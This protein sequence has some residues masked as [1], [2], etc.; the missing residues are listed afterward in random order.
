MAKLRQNK[1][2]KMDLF[3]DDNDVV[4]RVHKAATCEGSYCAIH[5]PSDHPMK[6]ARRVLRWPDPFSLKP[7]G[8]VERVCEHGVGHSDP[9]SVAFHDNNGLRGTGVHGCDGCCHPTEEKDMSTN[10]LD[11]EDWSS[12]LVEE[13]E[14][15]PNLMDD[16]DMQVEAFAK[17]LAAMPDAQG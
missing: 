17:Y 5:N 8:F 4:W 1:R 6:D 14:D 2:W 15:L 9:D 10:F 13:F 7:T 16:I 11:P 12:E 3:T